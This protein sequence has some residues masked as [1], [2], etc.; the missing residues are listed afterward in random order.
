MKT[1]AD[2]RKEGP[3]ACQRG[4]KADTKEIGPRVIRREKGRGLYE[5][6]RAERPRVQRGRG[7]GEE[8]GRGLELKAKR[9]GLKAG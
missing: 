8:G 4:E 5:E 1:K 2:A 9:R 7:R 6:R 3:R